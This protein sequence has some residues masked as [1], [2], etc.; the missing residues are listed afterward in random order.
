[1]KKLEREVFVIGHRNPDTDSICAAIAYAYLKQQQGWNAVAARAGNVNPETAFVLQ[2]FGQE[3]PQLLNDLYPRTKDVLQ[4]CEETVLPEATLR[5]VGRLLVGKGKKSIPVVAADGMLQGIVTVSDLASRYYREIE[6]ED[7]AEAGVSFNSLAKTI[8]AQFAAAAPSDDELVR[9]RVRIAAS[10]G[11]ALKTLLAKGDIVLLG[12][13]REDQLLSIAAGCACLILTTGATPSET[14]LAEAEKQ[15]VFIL[16]TLHDTYTVARLVQQSVPVQRVMRKAVVAFGP[17][18]LLADVR[19]RIAETNYRNYPITDNGRF[20]GMIDRSQM[21]VPQRPAIILV[22]HN[23][24]AQAVEGSE[25]ADILEIID[26]HRMGGLVTGD[27]IFIRE[28][29]IGSTSSIVANMIKAS[30]VAFPRAIAG[31]LL[32]A[33]ISDTLFF[34]SPTATE[35]DKQIAEELAEIADVEME[36]F[37][38]AVLKSGSEIMTKPAAKLIQGDIKE[39][40]FGDYRFAIGQVNTMDRQDALTREAELQE[41]LEEYRKKEHYDAALLMVTD[42]LAESTDLI[43]AGGLSAQL[44][45]AFGKP[46]PTGSFFLPGVLSRKKQII[47]PLTEAFR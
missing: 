14:V 4:P 2:Y 9:G 25:E 40:K 26:H 3:E 32:G 7:I 27:P 30:G 12:D 34:R 22:V 42:I 39:F 45:E 15:G 6:M 17:S 24:R 33:I 18:E 44:H 46:G 10:T 36:S 5:E 37:A 19:Q 38:L 21:I 1:M 35:I 13:R 28:E 20:V 43:V 31:V 47:P 23:E 8:D 41:A 29:P 11:E 16:T